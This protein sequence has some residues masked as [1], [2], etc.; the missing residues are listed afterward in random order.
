MDFDLIAFTLQPSI[1]TF[2]RCRKV[3]LLLIADF[4]NIS[5]PKEAAKKIIKQELRDRL[6]ETGILPEYA[7][8]K[9]VSPDIALGSVL[10]EGPPAVASFDPELAI[11]MKELDLR[12]K[13][14]ERE[15]LLVKLRVMEAETDRDSRRRQLGVIGLERED[16]PIPLPRSRSSSGSSSSVAPQSLHAPEANANFDVSRYLKLVP[17]FR[18]SEA[19]AY[20]VTF[21]RIAT[22]LSWP[23]DIWALFLQCSLSGKAQEVSS[24]LPLE[25]SLDYDTVKAAVLRAYELVPE[26]YRQKFRS[27]AKTAKQ[28]YVEFAREKRTLFEKWC[29]SSRITTLE[30]LQELILLEEFKNCVPESVEVHLNDQKVTSLID[31]AVLADEFALTH[32]NVF[33][34]ARRKVLPSP[35][36]S[37]AREESCLFSC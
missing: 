16:R 22:K 1:E 7:A 17:P 14:E 19:D 5:V 8:M 9:K 18:E 30:H 4:F 20:F 10:D 13:Q 35:D 2:E 6:V 27:H 31:A 29:F 28:T 25:Q 34:T 23:K 11:K 32:R 24:A 33:T 36:E 3:D 15:T 12:I 37:L 26:A 21:E